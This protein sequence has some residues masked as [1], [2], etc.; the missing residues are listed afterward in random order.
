[1]L[2]RPA[3]GTLPTGLATSNRKTRPVSRTFAA[4]AALLLVLPTLTQAQDRPPESEG[5]LDGVPK[6]VVAEFELSNPKAYPG[7]HRKYSVY[8]PSQLRRGGEAALMVFLDGHS[9]E[10]EYGNF[11]VPIVFDNLIAAGDMPPTVAIMIDPGMKDGQL[12]D[13]KY[14]EKRGWNPT[15]QNRSVEY[16]TMSDVF[17][18][19][20]LDEVL[21]E[22]EK[23]LKKDKIRISDDPAMRAACGSSSGGICAFTMAWERPGQFG[24]VI[25]HIGSFT[26]IRGGHNYEAMIRKEDPKP[27][28][29]ALQDGSGD[30]DN[31]FGNWWLANLQM[32]KALAFKGYDHKTWWGEGGHSGEDGG[33]VFVDELRWLWRD[34]KDEKS[35]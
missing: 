24:K 10:G 15:P 19:F 28:R 22:V 27:I 29:V 14:P 5:R 32:E 35:E 26:N 6:G 30:L 1:M 23:K 18:K 12:E 33:K 20:I 13:G 7:T 3:V 25:S 16:D 8:V 21:P 4:L 11:R 9:Y 31:Q 2:A 17:V 34:W